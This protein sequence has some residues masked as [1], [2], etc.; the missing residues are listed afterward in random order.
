MGHGGELDILSG[1]PTDAL[2]TGGNSTSV[3][4]GEGSNKLLLKERRV[5]SD[6]ARLMDSV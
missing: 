6:Y 2:G 3:V 1:D 4:V 5:F